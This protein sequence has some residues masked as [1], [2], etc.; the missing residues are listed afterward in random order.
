MDKTRCDVHI[1][2]AREGGPRANVIGGG[3]REIKAGA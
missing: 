3:L 2:A 1:G